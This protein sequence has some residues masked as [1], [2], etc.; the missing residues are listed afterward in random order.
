MFF[1]ILPG[2][3]AHIASSW[4]MSVIGH[5]DPGLEPFIFLVE[6]ELSSDRRA[7]GGGG[8]TNPILN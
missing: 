5:V 4:D 6:V 2:K 8:N 1:L 7:P 3:L